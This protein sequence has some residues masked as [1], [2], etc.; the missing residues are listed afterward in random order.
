[1]KQQPKS[2]GQEVSATFHSLNGAM[3]EDRRRDAQVLHERDGPALVTW[4]NFSTVGYGLLSLDNGYPQ[5][6]LDD[7]VQCLEKSPVSICRD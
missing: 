7:V 4:N 5:P 2:N 1:L 3:L 6:E